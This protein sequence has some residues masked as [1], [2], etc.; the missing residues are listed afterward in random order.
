MHLYVCVC[1]HARVCRY[2]L[3]SR[4]Y[5]GAVP[6][7]K[8]HIAGCC[9]TQATFRDLGNSANCSEFSDQTFAIGIAWDNI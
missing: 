5:L 2:V 4:V 6:V 3:V 7:Y 8:V 1:V 9:A